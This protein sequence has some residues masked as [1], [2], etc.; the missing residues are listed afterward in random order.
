MTNYPY[1]LER[2]SKKHL[3]PAC[4]CKTFVRV[5]EVSTGHY[6]PDHVGRCDRESN[7]GYQHTWKQYLTDNPEE[8]NER[9]GRPKK[10][11]ITKQG[12]LPKTVSQAVCLPTIE[13]K[14]AD[15]LEISFLFETLGN[16]HNNSFIQFITE[17]FPFDPDAVT[18]AV[19]EYKIGTFDDWTS[20]PVISK[21][22]KFCKAK[23]MKF[24][25][26]TGK[27]LKDK[28]GNGLI[29]S[30][31]AKLKYAG[32][33]KN[34][35]ETD[36]EVY[37]GEHLLTKY[38]DRPVAIVESEKTAVIASLCRGAFPFDFVWLATGSK[39]WLKPERIRRIG[40]NRRIVLYP[41]SD[42]FDKWQRIAAD[43]SLRS[44][45]V[46][47]SNLI[48]DLATESE[49]AEQVDLADYL[50]R[51]QRKRN[52]PTRRAAFRDL[53]EE[54]L[55]VLIFDGGMGEEEAENHIESSGFIAD[56][57]RL[58]CH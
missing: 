57:I 17:L 18:I 42:G 13:P 9:N 51:E 31:Q 52:D 15:Q 38:P 23:L 34:D 53:I 44:Y 3:C 54:R 35:F 26:S 58:V 20:F 12:K 37:F 43:P 24:D 8:R 47:V 11:Q 32:R 39:Q 36:K 55:A 45:H 1:E 6:L 49:K 25:H 21:Q 48:Q 14:K 28:D 19:K 29:H 33:L 40:R 16:Y 4:G 10:Q 5:I 2:G 22:G 46:K 56:S 50:I 27:R 30:L 7:C 41:D